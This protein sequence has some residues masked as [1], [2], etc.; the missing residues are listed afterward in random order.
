MRLFILSFFLVYGSMHAYA[1]LKARGALGFGWV[2]GTALALWM[3]CMVLA[4]AAVRVSEN[5]G[6]EVTARVLSH[7]AY[8]WLGLLFFFFCAAAAMDVYR[9]VLSAVGLMAKKDVAAL[10]PPAKAVFFVPLAF[11]VIASAVGYFDARNIRTE[12]I[13]IR[14]SKLP[15]EVERLRIVQI[16]DVHLG[17]IVRNDRLGLILDAV[18]K[19]EPD[20]L[21]STG[22]LVD[23]QINRMPGLAAMLREV[24]PRYGK[25]AITGNHEFYAG[26]DQA[27]GF[28][29]NAGFRV[30]RG[31]A[32]TGVINVAGVEDPTGSYFRT[33]R[34]VPEAELLRDLP[35][36]RFT[37]L[38]KHRP[39][40]EDSS[41]GL[42]D[43]QLSG[44]SH[45]GQLWPFYY[46]TLLFYP[47]V[48]MHD[49]DGGAVMYLSRGSGTWG[50]PVRFLAPPEV[51]LIELVRE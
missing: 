3:L 24:A 29:E 34:L 9:M 49:L 31:E 2:A 42:F 40:V 39:Y 25:Y 16:S 32:V 47:P 19:L 18:R 7:V 35:R 33:N 8:V 37:L 28:I 21:V 5:A 26:L 22:D 45:K 43:L 10:L 1:F 36:D 48:G 41:R 4:P 15:P 38:L 11:A 51:T 17:L 27:L 46:V 14:T 13:T 44:H 30:L 50:P 12:R 6:L 20:M 23:G